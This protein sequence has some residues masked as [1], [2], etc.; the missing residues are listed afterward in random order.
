MRSDFYVGVS[1]ILVGA[2]AISAYGIVAKRLFGTPMDFVQLLG[3][4][5]KTDSLPLKFKILEAL[6]R[7]IKFFGLIMIVLGPFIAFH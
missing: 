1:F 2:T 3:Y 6:L 4:H 5:V 7:V